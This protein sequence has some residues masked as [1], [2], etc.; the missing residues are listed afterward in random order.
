ME[1]EAPLRCKTIPFKGLHP[2]AKRE[3]EKDKANLVKAGLWNYISKEWHDCKSGE[4]L[5]V[6]ALVKTTE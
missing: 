2:N 3:I 4:L 5:L 6:T 1:E